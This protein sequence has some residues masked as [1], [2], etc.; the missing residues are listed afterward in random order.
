MFALVW[1]GLKSLAGAVL[2]IF[3]SGR[4]VRPLASAAAFL[5]VLVLLAFLNHSLDVE[6]LVRA[7]YPWLRRLW[8]PLVFLMIWS[9]C[10]LGAWLRRLLAEE[11][12]AA[13]DFP[14]VDAAWQQAVFAL[15]RAGVP[16]ADVPLYLVL[17]RAAWTPEAPFP[18]ARLQ[19]VVHQALQ[20]PDAPIH[21]YATQNAIYVACPGVSLLARHADLL[22]RTTTRPTVKAPASLPVPAA[23]RGALFGDLPAVATPSGAVVAP[24]PPPAAAPAPAVASKATMEALVPPAAPGE[25]LRLSKQEDVCEELLARTAHLCRR[26][27]RDRAPF[28]AANGILVLLPAPAL[29]D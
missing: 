3:P 16:L 24:P 17:G 11:S 29:D 22:A 21:V 25:R 23:P 9:L 18:A 27:A 14:D 5:A 4:A 13:S 19:L 1:K 8:L 10:W 6:R 12:L 7:P 20:N 2:S 28:C 15:N 26:L